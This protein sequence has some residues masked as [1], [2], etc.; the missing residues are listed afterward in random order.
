MRMKKNLKMSNGTTIFSPK[1][2]QEVKRQK[3]NIGAGAKY[4]QP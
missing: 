4:N 3:E 2:T 1:E